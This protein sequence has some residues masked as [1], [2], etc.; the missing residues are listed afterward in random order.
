MRDSSRIES[1]WHHENPHWGFITNRM[2]AHINTRHG[3]PQLHTIAGNGPAY[4]SSSF[5]G[6]TAVVGSKWG[7]PTY[8]YVNGT[9]AALQSKGTQLDFPQK[10]KWWL[11]VG[12][13]TV[14]FVVRV[15]HPNFVY[16][17][18]SIRAD[19]TAGTYVYEFNWLNAYRWRCTT[20]PVGTVVSSIDL[21]VLGGTV[22]DRWFGL[23]MTSG[24]YPGSTRGFYAG[25]CDGDWFDYGSDAYGTGYIRPSYVKLSLLAEKTYFGWDGEV[26]GLVWTRGEWTESEARRW[27]MNPFAWTEG[28]GQKLMPAP[29]C[30]QA[31]ADTQLVPAGDADLD[32]W[33]EADAGVDLA[34]DGDVDLD[35]TT[36]AD[37][38][39]DSVLEADA[40]IC[41]EDEL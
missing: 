36:E 28:Y 18:T 40:D 26:G 30:L 15:T 31:D 38:S 27:I 35:S 10:D 37:A 20:G 34:I 23:V 24:A 11:P 8:R 39:L 13:F 3:P 5:G 29:S 22:L 17:K 14:A 4:V 9:G 25:T 32:I 21:D 6:H 12:P 7:M 1:D 33:T 19:L 16:Q 2:L 41:P